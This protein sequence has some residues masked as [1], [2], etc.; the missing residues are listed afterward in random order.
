MKRV[1][2]IMQMNAGENG[3]AALSM[4]LAYYK[5]FVPISEVREQ[6][7]SSRNTTTVSQLCKAAEHYQLETVC[8]ECTDTE[9][10]RKLK[11]PVIAQWNKRYYAIICGVGRKTVKLCDPARGQ[12]NITVE[13]FWKRFGG[14]IL[15]IRPGAEFHPSGKPDSMLE[16]LWNHMKGNGGVF[17][18]VILIRGMATAAIIITALLS[19]S[20]MDEVMS[21]GEKR[22]I[23][24]FLL[25]LA[26]L[27]LCR[28]IMSV[29]E[30]LY[31]LKESRR[32]TAQSAV[33]LYKTILMQPMHFFEEHFS[34][35]LVHRMD[36]NT[37]L[38]Y[39]ILQ[40]LTPRAIDF[41]SAI[42]YIALMFYYNVPITCMILGV[43]VI[44]VLANHFLNKKISTV[45]R[46]I[47]TAESAANSRTLHG[48]DMMET[49]KITGA[50]HAYFTSWIDSQNAFDEG[51]YKLIR[52]YTLSGFLTNLRS[53][54][55][56][57]L[58]LFAGVF[59][60]INGSFTM[61]LLS[62]YMTV[63]QNMQNN[64]EQ[65]TD[66]MKELQLVRTDI[67]RVDD[68]LQMKTTPEIELG[69]TVPKKIKGD[70]CI[71]DVCFSYGLNDQ[72]IL[73]NFNLKIGK[74]ESVAIVGKTGCGKSTLLKLLTGL[75]QP[76][77]GEILYDGKSLSEIPT[78]IA[79][80]SIASADQEIMM[81]AESAG[82]NIRLWDELIEDY[83]MIHA[84]K[85]AQIHS[86]I[87]DSHGGYESKI[88]EHGRNYSGGE[89]QRI[90]LA[91]ALA[92]EPTVL[93]LDEFTSALDAI[94]EE[95]VF[96]AI[97]KRGITCVIAAHRLSTVMLCD[98]VIVMDHGKIMEEGAPLQLYNQGGW[99][100]RLMEDA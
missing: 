16:I 21:K 12:Y 62:L 72:T 68:I 26:F 92:K 65:M 44:Y 29:G 87:A 63:V 34:G 13:S 75:Y 88:V 90:E 83:E 23:L 61:G 9:K 96:Q 48:M 99:F 69:E 28:I 15:H 81:F 70:I 98:R 97:M 50:E 76:E 45:S 6:C 82:N 67:E 32:M 89:L 77:S 86:V 78:A 5:K 11:Y 20:I 4:I 2:L 60:I 49:I 73:E 3:A 30:T 27:V 91:R 79:H 80:A 64:M 58:L 47:S 56:S 100:T 19:R 66:I 31:I 43:E 55:S 85:D 52:L 18:K 10:L 95:K 74:G 25:T 94:T 71:K 17:G 1:P 57:A 46:S 41:A 39:T 84:A 54:L 7:V 93:I 53:Y 51:K 14:T 42:V 37:Y 40:K 35:D 38:N 36:A 33:N 24:P 59:F 22:L 8:E